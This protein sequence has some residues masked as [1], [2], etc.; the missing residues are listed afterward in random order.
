M[1]GFFGL[2]PRYFLIALIF[3]V[4]L[5]LTLLNFIR[6]RLF[7]YFARYFSFVVGL[8]RG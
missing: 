1:G 5:G 6:N 2:R 7:D 4:F 3:F 8:H